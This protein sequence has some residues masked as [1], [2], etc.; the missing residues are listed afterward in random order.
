MRLLL[1]SQ[2]EHKRRELEQLVHLPDVEL[3]G[4]SAV[5]IGSD[6]DVEE[7]GQTFEENAFLKARAFAEK[8]GMVTIADDSGLEVSALGGRPGVHSKRFIKGSASDRNHYVL[9]LL[10]NSS[11]RSAKFVAVLCVYDP[12]L[13]T[14]HFF[15]GEVKGTIAFAEAGDSGF[16]YDYIFI[17][18]GYDQTFAQLGPKMKNMIS[19]RARAVA[20]LKEFLGQ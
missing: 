15:R 2:N 17:P 3:I 1:A 11:D 20:K 14:H 18:E 13:K 19:H 4:P 6:F 9:E 8:S 7:T 10:K 5:G 12:V 16:E